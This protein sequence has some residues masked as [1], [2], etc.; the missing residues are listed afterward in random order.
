MKHLIPAAL[1]ALLCACNS[2]K[3]EKDT[4]VTD[5]TVT[6]NT[7]TPANNTNT[8]TPGA[9]SVMYS[10][11]DTARNMTGSVLV[12]KD[13]SNLSP[14]NNLLAILTAS[15][16]TD[17]SLTVNFLF[18]TKTGTY[19]VVGLG[20]VRGGEVYGGILGGEP[21]MTN[22][23]VNLTECTD[24]GS[25]NVGGH[26]W[27]ISGT[28]EGDITI[29]AMPLMKMSPGHP[30]NIKIAKYSFSNLVFDDNW[31]E[32]MEEGMKKLKEQ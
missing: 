15:S 22:Y 2:S 25:N 5:S 21:K 27:K 13:K 3:K 24:M 28:V 30:D 19:P 26:R 8:A 14:G 10:V 12:Q 9:G 29:D 16:N 11:N 17:E 4:T 31:E 32:L 23:K 7:T 20:F 6:S 18:T 1:V